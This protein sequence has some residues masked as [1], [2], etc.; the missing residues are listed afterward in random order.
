MINLDILYHWS[1]DGNILVI[2]APNGKL[3]T[4]G[5]SPPDTHKFLIINMSLIQ[6]LILIRKIGV[7]LPNN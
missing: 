7:Q 4:T 3:S 5:G 1:S 6:I 2:G